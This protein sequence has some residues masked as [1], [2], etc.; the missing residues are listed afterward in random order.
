MIFIRLFV[1]SL[2]PSVYA[3]SNASTASVRLYRHLLK[4]YEKN[5]RPS[6]RYDLPIQIIFTYSLIQIIDVDERNQILS[7]NGWINQNYF[8]YRLIWDPNEYENITYIHIPHNLIYLPDI[9]LYNNADSSYLKSIM[10]TDVVVHYN[11][12]V[13]WISAGIFKSSCPLD[14]TLYPFDKQICYLKFASWAF[15]GTKID[16]QLKSQQGDLSYYTPSSEWN[17]ILVRAEKQLMRYSCCPEPYPYIDIQIEIERRPLSFVFSLILP[18]VLISLVALLGFYMPSDSG[19]KVTLGITSLLSTTVVLMM[20]ADG[21]PPTSEALP[22]IGLYYGV[23]IFIVSLATAMTVFTLNL[24]HQGV[25]GRQIPA[26]IQ[27]L[28]FNYLAPI[29]FIKIDQ[30]HSL[31][32]HIEYFFNKNNRKK[33]GLYFK[34]KKSTCSQI[35]FDP[36]PSFCKGPQSKPFLDPDKTPSTDTFQEDFLMV[37]DKLHATIER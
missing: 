12:N 22:L 31:N 23:T 27:K 16:I 24:H 18:C 33:S 13:T 34:K 36:K 10:S 3:I 35:N 17:L 2:L 32:Q 37:L 25:N 11:G 4:D 9:V 21:M 28:A 29:L 7:T 6:I 19:E 15:D 26:F 30:Y 8:D 14:V 5:V 20:V 1:I